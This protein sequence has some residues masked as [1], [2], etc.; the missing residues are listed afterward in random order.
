MLNVHGQSSLDFFV[1]EKRKEGGPHKKAI[2][3][4]IEKPMRMRV[5]WL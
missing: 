2:T 5:I 4:K 3:K 1:T